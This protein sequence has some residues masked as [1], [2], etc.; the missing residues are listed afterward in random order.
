LLNQDV[1]WN[2]NRMIDGLV[3]HPAAV[4]ASGPDIDEWS[5]DQTVAAILA[6]PET[7]SL[8][9]ASEG[10]IDQ[11]KVAEAMGLGRTLAEKIEHDSI[12]RL[13]AKASPELPL[14]SG[15]AEP[16]TSAMGGRRVV[17]K[18]GTSGGTQQGDLFASG[19]PSD[20]S[21]GAGHATDDSGEG[22]D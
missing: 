13:K 17:S 11:T 21:L 6:L 20:P 14:G 19:L 8:D 9:V 2:G 1:R 22:G 10:G 7:C 4:E 16:R 18:R 5:E 3:L 12:N 15:S